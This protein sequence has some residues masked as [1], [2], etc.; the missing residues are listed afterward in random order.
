MVNRNSRIQE[1]GDRSNFGLFMVL[2]HTYVIR[3]KEFIGD[4]SSA[5]E[6]VFCSWLR[7]DGSH[8]GSE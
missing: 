4:I 8:V 1:M 5:N 3:L 2:R 7:K 6:C